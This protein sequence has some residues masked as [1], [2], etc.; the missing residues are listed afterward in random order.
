MAPATVLKSVA[1]REACARISV[2]LL[3]DVSERASCR[4]CGVSSARESSAGRGGRVHPAGE[5]DE[6]PRL[7]VCAYAVTHVAVTHVA[8]THVAVSHVAA[9]YVALPMWRYLLR[10][11]H[12]GAAAR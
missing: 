12:I 4:R 8:V 10:Y 2:S 5:I 9:T 11:R 7:H 6:C 1:G 3:P